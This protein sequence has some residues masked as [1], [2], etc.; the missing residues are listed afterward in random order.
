[1]KVLVIGFGKMGM[2]HA[3]TLQALPGITG[4]VLA[5]HSPLVRGA[6]RSLAP[7]TAVVEDFRE[8]LRDQAIRGA[9]IATPT[10]SHEP[11]YREL[12]PR[13]E[14]IFVEKPFAVSARQADEAIAAC[15]EDRRRCS[16]I[17]HC[18]RYAA[19]FEE[20]KRLI[21]AGAL[22]TVR[23]FE[24]SM[25]SS[26]VLTPSASWRF[27]PAEAGGG[28]LLD[29]GSHLVDMVRA[30]FGVPDSLTGRTESLVSAAAEDRFESTWT[31]AGFEGTVRGSWSEPEHRKVALQ[32][33]VTGANGTLAVSDDGVELELA[34]A[35]AG[36]PAGRHRRAITDLE[37]PV[38][39]DLAGPMY[40]RQLA[41]WLETMRDGGTAV[42]NTLDENLANL[43]ILDAIR[44]SGGA[45][46]ALV[47]SA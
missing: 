15:P 18:L 36:L 46:V 23:S 8:V 21:D 17:G 24:A 43:R 10:A 38:P 28:V 16:M 41:A 29:L 13:L 5:E 1:M 25:Y 6:L 20:A 34:A 37:S 40:T 26:D 32:V 19:P 2:L 12:A 33:A 45:P 30:F 9:V 39:F 27:R 44:G 31:Y 11:L 7:A 47:G 22:G 14:G 4:V 42:A 35:A 3:A